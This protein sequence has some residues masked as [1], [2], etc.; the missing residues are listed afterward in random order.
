MKKMKTTIKQ[1][2]DD[3]VIKRQASF[4]LRGDWASSLSLSLSHSL[5]DAKFMENMRQSWKAKQMFVYRFACTS[6]LRQMVSTIR[7]QVLIDSGLWKWANNGPQ[8]EIKG[9]QNMQENWI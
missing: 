5:I 4:G 3:R 1:S 8:I 6:E 2:A 7:Q 9:M